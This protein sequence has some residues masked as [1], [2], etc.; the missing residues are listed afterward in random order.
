MKKHVATD[1]VTARDDAARGRPR[2]VAGGGRTGTVFLCGPSFR[3]A[4]DERGG[5]RGGEQRVGP[6][7]SVALRRVEG[8]RRGWRRPAFQRVNPHFTQG[9]V[10]AYRLG[11]PGPGADAIK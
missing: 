9:V 5:G 6:T 8:R 11:E 1:H 3:V 4:V 7:C 10:Q 2:V